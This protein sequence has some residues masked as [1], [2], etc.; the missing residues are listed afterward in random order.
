MSAKNN[1]GKGRGLKERGSLSTFFLEAGGGGLNLERV[2]GNLN[3]S[4]LYV[5]SVVL[6]PSEL[7]CYLVWT[8][9]AIISLGGQINA[10]RNP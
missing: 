2:Y 3:L 10:N 9:V 8:F 7:V 1:K 4:E 5:V 6:K